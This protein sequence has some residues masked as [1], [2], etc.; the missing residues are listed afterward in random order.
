MHF[1]TPQDPKF[2][3]EFS[4]FSQYQGRQTARHIALKNLA[5]IKHKVS[6]FIWLFGCTKRITNKIF[7]VTQNSRH[8][9]FDAT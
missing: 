1:K 5:F 2:D 6:F 3:I 9:L 8:E 4:I 7:G